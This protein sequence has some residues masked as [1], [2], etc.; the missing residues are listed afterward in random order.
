LSAV[1]FV[2]FQNPASDTTHQLEVLVGGEWNLVATFTGFTAT[3]DVLTWEPSPPM[4]QVEALRMT[5]SESLSWPE[6]YEIE[7]DGFDSP[8]RGE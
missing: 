5:T 6:W 1:R 8:P 2:V 7:I 4:D 3:G